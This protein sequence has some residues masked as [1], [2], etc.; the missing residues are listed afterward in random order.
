MGHE[1]RTRLTSVTH[2]L[3]HPG[4]TQD[5]FYM[6][7]RLLGSD[8]ILLRLETAFGKFMEVE[9][10][11][12]STVVLSRK[13]YELSAERGFPTGASTPLKTT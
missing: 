1:G 6:D 9:W 10:T 5:I 8:F 11:I 2:T 13:Q 3:L 7:I 4:Y 12:H